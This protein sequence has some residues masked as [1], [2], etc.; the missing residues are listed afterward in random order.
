MIKWFNFTKNIVTSDIE[1][2]CYRAYTHRCLN[3]LQ[4]NIIIYL[5]EILNWK[6][7]KKLFN[8]IML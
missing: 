2:A 6:I 4:H 7:I 1:L 3:I 5:H 8:I